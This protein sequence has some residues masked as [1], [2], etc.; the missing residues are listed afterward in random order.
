MPSRE[1][2]KKKGGA[3]QKSAKQV[4]FL[5]S[6]VSPLSKKQKDKLKKELHEKKV[7]IKKGRKK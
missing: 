1:K 6:K 7:K 2:R 5:L 3:K 4:R